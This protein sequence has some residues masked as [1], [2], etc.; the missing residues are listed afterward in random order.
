M[1]LLLPGIFPV[2][3]VRNLY[4]GK[5]LPV[6]CPFFSGQGDLLVCFIA[7]LI[8]CFKMTG[9]M[10]VSM[11][12]LRSSS[13]PKVLHNLSIYSFSLMY[14]LSLSCIIHMSF[15]L[16]IPVASF[17]F[18]WRL[19]ESC[20]SKSMYNF[21]AFSSQLLFLWM[22]PFHLVLSF[23]GTWHAMMFVSTSFLVIYMIIIPTDIEVNL[24]T[25]VELCWRQ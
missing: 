21:S 16:R 23:I 20:F 18:Q 6:F 7:S 8:Y 25:T 13:S 19:S 22:F 1:L 4:E 9:S 3:L 17:I 5:Y 14:L 2:F 11:S 10:V 24:V 15:H 12:I